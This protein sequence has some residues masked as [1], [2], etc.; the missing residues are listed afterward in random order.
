MILSQ[1]LT[2]GKPEEV[3]TIYARNAYRS[4]EGWLLLT[5]GTPKTWGNYSLPLLKRGGVKFMSNFCWLGQF[6]NRLELSISMIRFFIIPK[7]YSENL[8]SK[9]IWWFYH[10]FTFFTDF[11]SIEL[12]LLSHLSEDPS[13]VQ[14]FNDKQCA[15]VFTTLASQWYYQGFITREKW[16]QYRYAPA[17]V[18]LFSNGTGL[19]KVSMRN[20]IRSV[21]DN[22]F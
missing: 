15:D 3:V 5:A 17:R 9:N 20:L 2:I 16:F 21:T 1:F 4:R 8:M 6:Q 7:A 11:Q 12:R 22:N 13:L 18:P 10:C 14:I 19:I